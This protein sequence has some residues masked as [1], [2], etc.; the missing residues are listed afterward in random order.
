MKLNKVSVVIDKE[1]YTLS[2][3]DS[4]EY[5][6]EVASYINEKIAEIYSKKSDAKLNSRLKTLYIS[7]NIADDLFKE[8]Q[9]SKALEEEI[10]ILKREKG[11]NDNYK[12]NKNA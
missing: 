4:P 2:S 1:T 11:K 9:K 6:E 12:K 7:L 5:I 10:L 8:R 3:Y